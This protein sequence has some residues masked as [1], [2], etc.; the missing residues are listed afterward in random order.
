MCAAARRQLK[1]PAY[2][3][4]KDYWRDL[5]KLSDTEQLT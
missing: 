4:K 3:H 1:G 2:L 5:P